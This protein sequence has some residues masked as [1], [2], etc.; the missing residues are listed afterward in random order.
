MLSKF[1]EKQKAA[2]EKT[3]SMQHVEHVLQMINAEFNIYIVFTL[4]GS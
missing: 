2:A 4:I 1:Q 3:S